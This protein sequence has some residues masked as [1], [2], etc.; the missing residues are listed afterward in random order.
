VR[1]ST[2]GKGAGYT[3]WATVYNIKQISQ[4]LLF[5][6]EHDVRDYATLADRASLASSRFSELSQKIKSLEK[7]LGEIVVLKTHIINYSKTKEVYVAYRKAGYSKKF[8]EAHREEITLHKAAKQAFSEQERK[9][10]RVKELN[11]EYAEVLAEKKKAY[12]EYREAK[13]DMQDYLTAK[14]NID[15]FLDA[16]Q[17]VGQ[18]QKKEKEKESTR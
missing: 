4:A 5:L 14:H 7:R 2:Q 16:D 3:R 12:A 9:I 8:F 15:T 18:N 17:S 1:W 11:A 6:E 13:K 10:P